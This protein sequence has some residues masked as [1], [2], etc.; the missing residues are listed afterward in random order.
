MG[1]DF[2]ERFLNCLINDMTYCLEEGIA[3]LEKINQFEKRLEQEGPS[4]M[5]K[6]DHDNHN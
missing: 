4:R 6:E 3:K 2:F 5:S 1:K